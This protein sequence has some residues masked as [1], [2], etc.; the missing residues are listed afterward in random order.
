MVIVCSFGIVGSV[1]DGS[2]ANQLTLEEDARLAEARGV[3]SAY[4]PRTSPTPPARRDAVQV[5]PPPAAPGAHEPPPNA[6]TS[7]P[8]DRQPD[9]LAAGVDP[10]NFG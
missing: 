3:T 8:D 6:V 7:I 9:P 10:D 4:H 5:D 2:S 1:S